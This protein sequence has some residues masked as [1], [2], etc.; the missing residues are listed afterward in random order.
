MPSLTRRSFLRIGTGLAAAAVTVDAALL[1]PNRPRLVEL[2][3]PL[4]RL[5]QAWSG[6]RVAQLSDFHYDHIFSV[7]ALRKAVDLLAQVRPD[8]IVL[9]GD[10]ITAPL[11]SHN[12]RSRRRAA[13]A[14]GPCSE[15][16]KRLHAPE[17]IFACLGNHDGFSDPTYI[18]A[19]LQ[20]CGIHVLRNSSVALERQGT[21]LWLAGVQDVLE[22]DPDLDLALRGIP[23][24]DA[25][26]LLA[27]EPD[28][29]ED[30]AR[31]RVDLQLS[32]HS[33][34]G[35]V[36]IPFFGAPVLPEM[37]KKF[38]MGLYRIG[39]LTLYTNAGLGTVRVP[40]RFDC[41]PEVTLFTLR[42]APAGNS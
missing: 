41:P 35:Q 25:V 11:F 40:V 7:V 19:T 6:L 22:E 34:G 42:S 20:T 13:A 24:S 10:F 12:E 32:G 29:A 21:R 36:R 4:R 16:L 8:L 18:T 31:H 28:F 39:G 33:H 23:E 26:I 5:S 1:E 27:H 17:G 38:P 30:V 9:T 37:A 3:L 2:D 15:Y 14:I